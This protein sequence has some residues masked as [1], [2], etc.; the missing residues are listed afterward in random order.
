[1]A[2]PV[3]S[4]TAGISACAPGALCAEHVGDAS[5]ISPGPM[6]ILPLHSGSQESSGS[7]RAAPRRVFICAAQGRRAPSSGR[8]RRFLCSLRLASALGPFRDQDRR[9]CAGASRAVPRPPGKPSKGALFDFPSGWT[10][11]ILSETLCRA[12][13]AEAKSF[14]LVDT[15]SAA[16]LDGSSARAHER[17]QGWFGYYWA[18]TA[19]LGKCPVARLEVRGPNDTVARD[20]C[21]SH[22]DCP[23]PPCCGWQAPDAAFPSSA[24]S[25]GMPRNQPRRSWRNTT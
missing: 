13:A 6:R 1:M 21:I 12:D 14:E 5:S 18:P 17:R 7:S 3:G 24:R 22:P 10:S 20:A 4:G 25:A 15:G 2:T 23:A 19:I 8:G 9:G 16:G 11:Q